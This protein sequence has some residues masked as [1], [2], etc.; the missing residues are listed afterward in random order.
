[1]FSDHCLQMLTLFLRLKLTRVEVGC[2][3]IRIF[4]LIVMDQSLDPI[5]NFYLIWHHLVH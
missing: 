1:M 4:V 2:I 5:F 3:G